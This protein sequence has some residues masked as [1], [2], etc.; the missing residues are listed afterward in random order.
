MN[1]RRPLRLLLVIHALGPG[2]A[3]R[4]L[5]V[6]ANA[7]AR[8]GDTVR[9]AT[10]VGGAE[11]PFYA[12][13]PAIEVRPLDVAGEGKNP[14]S[15]LANNVRRVRAIRRAIREARP[16]V[17][18][19]FMN[20]TNV[21]TIAAARGL[22]VPVLATE[23]I[24]PTQD[25]IGRLWT[26]L[27]GLA[28]PAAARVLLLSERHL[29]Y[30]PPG[31][32]RIAR[33]LPNPVMAPPPAYANGGPSVAREPRVIAMGRMTAQKGFDLLL[34]AFARVAPA[35]REWSLVLFGDGPL[36]GAIGRQVERLGLSE[37]VRLVQ[38][39]NDPY[40]ELARSGLYVLSSRYEGFPMVLCEAMSVG[41][42]VVAFDC[43]TGPREILRPGIDGV[44]VPAGDVDALAHEMGRLMADPAERER[45]GARAREI[46][47]RFS[48]ERVL[49]LWD[50]VFSE[51]R[52]ER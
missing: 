31:V 26:S 5:S 21:L 19:P 22:G 50:E 48:V 27:R 36:A 15:K 8:R 49:G 37:R 9:V 52:G 33:V 24:D 29:E 41:L 17:V 14:L 1:A 4:V 47:E 10:L 42:P 13:D 38:R 43:R 3:E 32:R 40:G 12:L 23:H 11:P 35:H 39:T 51:V 2:G 6:L 18:I 45:L 16:D 46:P 20:V 30:F 44:L 28:Y 34:E 25:D 7:W